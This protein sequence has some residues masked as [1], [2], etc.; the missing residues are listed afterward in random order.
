MD[1]DL[2]YWVALNF[3]HGIGAARFRQLLDFF[4]NARGAWL[5]AEGDLLQ[6]GLP[7]RI[8][9]NLLT[10]RAALDVE[11]VWEKIH[12]QGIRVLTWA[13]AA[14]PERL[15]TLDAPPPVLYL[16]GDLLPADDWA[17][18]IVGTR[19]VTRYGRQ[20]AEELAA[21]LAGQGITVVSGLARGVDGVAHQAALRAGG[22]TLAVLGCGV[23]QVYPPE[24]RHL[25]EEIC[26]QG[27]LLSDYAPGTPPDAVNFPPRNRII[28]GLSLAVVVVEAGESSGALI[29][30]QFALEQG[31]EVF[32]VP[33]SIYAP[34]SIGP[35]RLIKD[36]AHPLL[37]VADLLEVLNISRVAQYKQARLALPDDPVE[38][39]LLALLQ[40][41]SLHVDEL[42]VRADLPIA[43]VSAA[44]TMMELKGLVRQV[45][46]MHYV[47]VREAPAP[48]DTLENASHDV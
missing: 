18:A 19:R 22:R 47:A 46:N 31:R 44:L 3:V 16:R 24:H 45:G 38:A 5:A 28:A 15:R 41:E 43:Q 17:V 13:D 34:L 12:A 4:G 36:G 20:V 40:A 11:A 32:A 35:N 29:T 14:Y 1:A 23:D 6:S 30:A 9:Q 21:A 2:P 48:Y 33:G 37:S 26:A 10:L 8:C 7:E 42:G 39:R 25:A 27:A